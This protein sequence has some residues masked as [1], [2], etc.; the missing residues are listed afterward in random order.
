M[1]L[2]PEPPSAGAAPSPLLLPQNTHK[3]LIV[4]DFEYASANTP[5]MEFANHFT[6]WCYNYHDST[7]SWA[8]NT[9]RYPTLE[10]QRAFIRSYVNHRVQFNPR[11][12]ATPKLV[13]ADGISKGSISEFLLDSRAPGGYANSYA[14]DEARR[15]Q[16]VER[17]VD[18]LLKEVKIWRVANSAQWVAWG[19]VQAK[20]PECDGSG[21][22][23]EET[24]ERAVNETNGTA[25]QLDKRPEGLVAE[26]M[27]SG[28]TAKEAEQLED[29]E[30]HF[31]YLGYA[32]DRARFFWGDIVSL[33][34]VK[35]EDLPA[36][37]ANSLKVVDN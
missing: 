26:A 15:E 20:V 17:Q 28:E 29:D 25:P 34:L 3:Q 9:S 23:A 19:I 33:G 6:E 21:T 24:D 30:D 11:A 8:C 27:L 12:S 18:A 7:K 2:I 10:Q 16:D 31:D 1:R 32:Q 35:R 14:E 4:I 5:G 22:E 36:E 13:A 37:L